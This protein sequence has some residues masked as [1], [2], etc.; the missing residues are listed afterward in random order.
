MTIE[1]EEDKQINDM[2]EMGDIVLLDNKPYFVIY[3]ESDC[4]EGCLLIDMTD[5]STWSE[6]RF[7][8]GLTKSEL[9]D[10]LKD[11]DIK[12]EIVKQ[13]RYDITINIK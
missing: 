1:R 10:F 5:G 11:R 3:H 13:F 6:E 4:E 2:V 12:V 9:C 7:Y 8:S